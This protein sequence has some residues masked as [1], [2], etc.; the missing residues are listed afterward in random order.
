MKYEFTT[1][2]FTPV[3]PTEVPDTP[4]Q[5][6]T[7]DPKPEVKK[8]TVT[9][10]NGEGAT[11]ESQVVEGEGTDDNIVVTL[12]EAPVKDGYVFEG[13]EDAEGNVYQPSG[14]VTVPAKGNVTL[15]GTWKEDLVEY[16]LSFDANKLGTGKIDPITV[17]VKRGETAEVTIPELDFATGNEDI[18]HRGYSDSPLEGAQAD[19]TGVK[20]HFGEK[21]TLN[22]NKT[23]YA[24]YVNM[25]SAIGGGGSISPDEKD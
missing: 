6:G 8:A 24:V 4:N 13:W 7:E 10:N 25:S 12:P 9:L 5:G 19:Q 11:P 2:D 15:T 3:D 20:Y 1:D 22:G 16:T 17:K 18:D 14:N 21:I 23:L